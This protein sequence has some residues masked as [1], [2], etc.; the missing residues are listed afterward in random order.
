MLEAHI[1][2]LAQMI[3]EYRSGGE[4]VRQRISDHINMNW[5]CNMISVPE[6][7]FKL[8]AGIHGLARIDRQLCG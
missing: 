5:K 7:D 8:S 6:L 1:T 4:N 2:E 3:K